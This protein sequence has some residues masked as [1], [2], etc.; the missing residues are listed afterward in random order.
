MF[1]LELVN[2]GITLID[3]EDYE[4]VKD[5]KWRLHRGYAQCTDG[6]TTIMLHRYIMEVK[7]KRKIIDHINGDKLDNRKANLRIVTPSQNCMNR[8]ISSVNTSGYKG[9]CWRENTAGRNWCA[10]IYKDYKQ[11]HLG[12]FS[13]KIEA[14]KAYDAKA[15][16]MF[17]EYA[18]T[19]F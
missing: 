4:K 18:L 9:V 7:A 10:T 13:T 14:A 16:E 2:G 19:N 3:K 15:K 8:R 17:G 11:Y 6:K 12:Y 5:K 1:E